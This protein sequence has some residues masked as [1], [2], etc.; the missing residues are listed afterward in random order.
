MI[1]FLLARPQAPANQSDFPRMLAIEF[2]LHGQ[3]ASRETEMQP[4]H[5]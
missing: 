5:Q 1:E 3:T 2:Q 4:F